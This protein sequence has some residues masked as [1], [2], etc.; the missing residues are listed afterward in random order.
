MFSISSRLCVYV[1]CSFAALFLVS[2]GTS[3]SRDGNASRDGS[4]QGQIER[5]RNINDNYTP[6]YDLKAAQEKATDVYLFRAGDVTDSGPDYINVHINNSYQS[7]L[8]AGAYTFTRLCPGEHTVALSNS[9]TPGRYQ[10]KV[11]AG[12]TITVAASEAQYYLVDGLNLIPST[13]GAFP[14]LNAKQSNTIP[15]VTRTKCVAEVA[16]ER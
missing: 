7:S 16:T 15:R 9:D 13:E 2:C 1:L 6:N 5:W 10:S 12:Q 11:G 14:G 4:M 8:Q 3:S